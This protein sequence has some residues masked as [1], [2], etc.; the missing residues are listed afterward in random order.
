VSGGLADHGA[1]C[2]Q[3]GCDLARD[4]R[5]GKV[6]RRDRGHYAHGLAQR[7]HAAARHGRGDHLAV[8]ARG[9]FAEP[10][11]V[12]R[13]I[14]HLALALGQGLALFEGDQLAQVVLV[15][16]H[17]VIPALDDR[18]AL[19]G[20]HLAPCRKGVVGGV[21]RG[22]GLWSAAVGHFCDDV[23]G[24]RVGDGQ[25]CGGRGAPGAADEV[26]AA[27]QVGAGEG[28]RHGVMSQISRQRLMGKRK[29]LWF[30]EC[31]S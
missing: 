6:P 22:A 29:Q 20:R 8:H 30:Q 21:Q 16:Q 14:G 7:E 18:R 11:D 31:F 4:H 3:R 15:R 12:A 25:A 23:A 26:G 13:G 5:G 1:A 28:E 17:E 24:G 2:G 10:F 19:L 9:F 27:N